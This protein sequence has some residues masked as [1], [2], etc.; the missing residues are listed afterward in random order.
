MF[1]PLFFSETMSYSVTQ[2]VLEL[3]IYPSL[4][5]HSQLSSWLIFPSAGIIC[6]SLHA[7]LNLHSLT[8]SVSG[9]RKSKKKQVTLILNNI[10][11]YPYSQ[12]VFISLIIY[13]RSYPWNISH[14]LFPMLSLW[15]WVCLLQ[16]VWTGY[17]SNVSESHVARGYQSCHTVPEWEMWG[18]LET[19]QG[20]VHWPQ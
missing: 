6:K 1:C 5:L 17:I 4:V 9:A 18:A 11:F 8:A 12:N 16:L 14:L 13:I 19:P 10:L 15:N 2:A 7:R 3:A 20:G